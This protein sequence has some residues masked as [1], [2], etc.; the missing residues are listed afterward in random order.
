MRFINFVFLKNIYFQCL[1]KEENG[2][3]ITE[4]DKFTSVREIEGDVMVEVSYLN[5]NTKHL[6][7]HF[8][9]TP[10]RLP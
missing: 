4:S 3:L 8:F 10:M 2:K 1:I 5:Y 9:F 7:L 6:F